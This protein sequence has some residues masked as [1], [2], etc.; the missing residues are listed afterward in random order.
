[1]LAD[2]RAALR[3]LRHEPGYTAAATLTLALTIGA[4]TAIFS[5][6]HK[7][8]LDSAGIHDPQSLVMAWSRDV[9]RQ[10]GV[11]ELSYRNVED[12]AANSRSFASMA[13]V[14]S[15][16]WPAILDGR[17]DPE[18][19]SLAGV[20]VSF[21]NTLGATP[22]L[23][24][25]FE[26]R[27]DLP[28][29]PRVVVLSHGMWAA[30]FGGDRDVVGRVITL[31]ESPF[32][33]AG[34]MPQGFDFPR[35]TDVWT[36]V[37]PV[38]AASPQGWQPKTL[39][40]VAVLFAIGRL[41]ESV[42]SEAAR[43]ELDAIAAR[44]EREGGAH[45]FASAVV[46]TPFLDYSLGPVR[47]ALWA[48]FGAVAVLLLIGC[49]NVSGL[50]LTRAAVRRRDHAVRLA[51]GATPA[52]IGRL[53]IAETAVLCVAGGALG[54]LNA[55]WMAQVMIAVAPE[56][57]PRLTS[58]AIDAPVAAFT[59]AVVAVATL[60]CGA[61]PVRHALAS[62]P[63]D[64]L[65]D[66]GRATVGRSVQRS[67]SMLVALEIGLAV[68]LMIAAGLVVRSFINLRQIHLGFAPSGVLTMTVSPRTTRPVNEW[69][70]ELLPRVAALPDVE[71]AGAIYLRPLA[72][73]PIGQETSFVLEGQPDTQETER[74]NPALNYQVATPGYFG[75]MRIELKRGRVFT[76]DDR[77]QSPR[78]ALVGETAARRLWPGEDAVGK[79]L[80]LPTFERGTGKRAWRQVV[81]VVSDLRYRGVDDVRLDVYDP[82]S[83]SP[84]E[85]ADLVVRTAGDPLRAAA[86]VQAAARELDPRV[87]ISGLT[88]MDAIVAR[89]LAPWRF[90]VWVFGVFAA[91]AVVL[92]SGGLFSIV[93]LDVGRRR[94]E[95]AVRV[96]LGAQRRDIVKSVLLPALQRLV[97]GLAFGLIV[98]AAASG[99]LRAML[100][101]VE[102]LDGATYVA[103]TLLISLVVMG[104]SYL[105]ARRAAR[106]DPLL[107]LRCE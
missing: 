9:A 10:L 1:M 38:L 73:G 4:T 98:S 37:V 58:I 53:W 87:L 71:A 84:L 99:V 102:P 95:L 78:V 32:T 12:W 81:G 79:R 50:M 24:R 5:G 44:I 96:A 88:T 92:A 60:A 13:A 51:L 19:R 3:N 15:S 29:A 43:D 105:P 91:L 55:R 57:L 59:C 54:I 63:L 42:T 83:Q 49:A 17:G 52:A 74:R 85:A 33:I 31:D 26:S 18:R 20:S 45:R 75:A 67:R 7:V 48:L 72:L 90:S 70:A 28:N 76:D 30:R 47:R 56:N 34:V 35:G 21:F 23:G 6:V 25:G 106:V 89:A 27:D 46:I 65:S 22:M 61:G 93:S 36:P 39:E 94:R 104:A 101:G 82:A 107:T 40:S 77:A 66:S 16:T 80:L 14:G 62:S 64:G 69:I 2:V 103:A 100:F 41:R 97:A 8:L 11:V 86:A 68:A